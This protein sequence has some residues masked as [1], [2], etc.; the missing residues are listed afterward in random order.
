MQKLPQG[1]EGAGRSGAPRGIKNLLKAS[2][3]GRQHRGNLRR[4]GK[5]QTRQK[6]IAHG[7][8]KASESDAEIQ[9]AEGFANTLIPNVIVHRRTKQHHPTKRTHGRTGEQSSN[10]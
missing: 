7:V 2:E 1:K 8:P 6:C 5:L 9:L 10:P 3:N 4:S